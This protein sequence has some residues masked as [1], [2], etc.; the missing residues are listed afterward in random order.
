MWI[1]GVVPSIFI[2]I[3]HVPTTFLPLSSPH[4]SPSLPPSLPPSPPSL[5]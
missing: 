4:N 5:R 2:S 3:F 1:A